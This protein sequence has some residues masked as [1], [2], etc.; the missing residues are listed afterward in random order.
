MPTRLFSVHFCIGIVVLVLAMPDSARAEGFISPLLGYDWGGASGCPNITGCEDKNLNLGIGV[1]SMEDGIGGELEISYAK[2]FF[3]RA[4]GYK[5]SVLTVMGN[6]LLA[7]K[8]GPA[9]PFATGG[10]GLIKT[11]IDFTPTSLLDSHNNHFGWDLGGGLMIFVGEHVG[12][13]GDLRHFKSFKAARDV[14]SHL[15]I[16]SWISTVRAGR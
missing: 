11:N 5:S 13:R 9:R 14:G 2:D 1:G 8:Y 7:P 4:P 16:R 12:V 10:L 3:G 15:A 6:V